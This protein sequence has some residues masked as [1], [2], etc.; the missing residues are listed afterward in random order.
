MDQKI[1]DDLLLDM[2][3]EEAI[4]FTDKYFHKFAD[5]L[6]EMVAE[7]AVK[8]AISEGWSCTTE[9]TENQLNKIQ[10]GSGTYPNPEMGIKPCP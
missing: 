9:L 10:L 4:I 3:K 2:T 1:K 6:V 5:I 8:K 7:M